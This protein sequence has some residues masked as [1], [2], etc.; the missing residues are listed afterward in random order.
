M[1]SKGLLKR[2]V[3]TLFSISLLSGSVAGA[4]E[5]GWDECCPP[6][7]SCASDSQC[8]NWRLRGSYLYWKPC[9]KGISLGRELTSVSSKASQN[10]D[11]TA[12]TQNMSFEFESGFKV[13]VGYGSPCCNWDLALDWTYFHASA[14]AQAQ[15]RGVSNSFVGSGFPTGTF[16]SSDWVSSRVV[17]PLMSSARWT[18]ALDLVDLSLGYTFCFQECFSIRPSIGLRGTR[19]DQK[20]HVGSNVVEFIAEEFAQTA[21]E[22]TCDLKAIGPRVA[23]DM[24]FD[25][26][27][28]F[29]IFGSA[30]ASLLYGKFHTR[31][32]AALQPG[33]GS[34]TFPDPD[35][36]LTNPL[37][38]YE[39][40]GG[41][42]SLT[43]TTV[44]DLAIGLKWERCYQ[45]CDRNYTVGL[46]AA[47]EFHAFYDVNQF[48]FDKIP[49]SALLIGGLSAAP[50]PVPL[51]IGPSLL[52]E[53]QSHRKFGDLTTQGLTISAFL[54]F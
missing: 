18:M 42:P 44:T 46:A 10:T 29:A 17:Q 34:T 39:I 45:A 16:F 35:L 8:G 47:W 19:L 51:P 11:F 38:T 50:D 37:F 14:D 26:G 30:G 43:T 25:C 7:P 31:S 54:G 3:S 5:C 27:C 1:H 49:L 21:V 12:S 22:S 4:Q 53:P 32:D 20:Y 33:P 41:V 15:G 6:P 40:S 13:G 9:E 36:E 2:I 48:D 23:V 24:E 52:V 28:G